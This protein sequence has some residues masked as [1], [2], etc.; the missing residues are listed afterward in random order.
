LR[1]LHAA[2]TARDAS[3]GVF[4]ALGEPTEAASA[5]ATSH[6]IELLRGPAL[7][8]LVGTVPRPKKG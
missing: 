2:M 6:G 3:T 7:V 4:V 8:A 5:Y 1:E